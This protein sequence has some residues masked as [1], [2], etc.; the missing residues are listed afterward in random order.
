[1][2]LFLDKN[3]G[4]IIIIIIGQL[5]GEQGIIKVS[6]ILRCSQLAN[7]FF[8][9]DVW[10]FLRIARNQLANIYCTQQA[11]RVQISKKKGHNCAHISKQICTLKEIFDGLIT[12]REDIYSYIKILLI[13]ENYSLILSLLLASLTFVSGFTHNCS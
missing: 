6:C 2:E 1:M 13:K 4:V 8:E 7:I 9:I 5:A 11:V 12:T 3:Y 10:K